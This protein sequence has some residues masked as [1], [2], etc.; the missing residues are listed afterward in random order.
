MEET[1]AQA[2]SW[3]QMGAVLVVAILA[4]IAF[5][6]QVMRRPYSA[7]ALSIRALL[8]LAIF[9]ALIVVGGVPLNWVWAAVFA[10]IGAALGFVSGRASKIT[11]NDKGDVVIKKA[12]W[13]AL[14]S[15]LSYV[16]AT[17]A[18]LYG[19]A[20][21]FSASLLLVLLGAMMTVGATVSE[22]MKGAAG[23]SP[24]HAASATDVAA[25]QP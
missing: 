23:T 5:A 10:A 6:V 13:P 1:A 17:A 14:V 15:A 21:M 19:T 3:V 4:M 18:L 20:G 9:V 16:I 11:T 24:Q 22:I 12:P 8:A 2:Y 25:G 7:A